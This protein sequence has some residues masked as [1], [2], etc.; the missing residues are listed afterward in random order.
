MLLALTGF[1]GAAL[2]GRRLLAVLLLSLAFWTKFAVA[3]VLGLY[4]AFLARGSRARAALGAVIA[5]GTGAV[6]LLP[7]WRGPG[8]LAGPMAALR[9]NPVRTS[10]SF[11]EIAS[12]LAGL[13]SP[14]AGAW[15]YRVGW[16]AGLALLA[17][18]AVRAARRA[19]TVEAVLHESL[20]FLL[21]YLL[22]ASPFVQPWYLTWL[23]PLALVEADP[24]WRRAVALY[25]AL[26]LVAWG[27]DVP[28]LQTLA[29]N[30]PVLAYL[31]RTRRRGA[32]ARAAPAAA[33]GPVAA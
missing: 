18:L 21:A 20:V 23:L 1:V 31:W 7:W 29:V 16:G 24:R 2:A 8:S 13:W 17:V 15:A 3:P 25:C 4:L 30:V 28:P 32:V 33:R 22:V 27:V 9:A 19:R 12:L 26:T 11:T 10:R 6:L 14:A 5:A